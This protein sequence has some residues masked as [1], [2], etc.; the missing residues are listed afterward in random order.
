MN[1]KKN[2]QKQK[3]EKKKI[4]PP[5]SLE[6]DKP[7]SDEV[8][9]FCAA[10]LFMIEGAELKFAYVP[11]RYKGKGYKVIKFP[12]GMC[13]PK[14][15]PLKAVKR[16]MEEELGVCLKESDFSFLLHIETTSTQSRGNDQHFKLFFVVKNEIKDKL[17]D[18]P[19]DEETGVPEWGSLSFL[20]KNLYK[21]HSMVFNN[22]INVFFEEFIK[23]NN[24]LGLMGLYNYYNEL[25]EKD[26]INKIRGLVLQKAKKDMA[27]SFAYSEFLETL[28][29]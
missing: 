3:K 5:L 27:F 10:I 8:S 14:E 16:E 4:I 6:L 25:E 2:K 24:T 29:I 23:Q 26:K 18:T 12:G 19:Y 13:K 1:P 22:V 9:C 15:T 17:R 7:I 11:Y 28:N 20:Q 21:D